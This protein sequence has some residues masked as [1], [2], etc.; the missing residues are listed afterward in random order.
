MIASIIIASII[1]ASIIA[2][3]AVAWRRFL[4]AENRR[5]FTAR[6]R[7]ALLIKPPRCPE[8]PPRRDRRRGNA[9]DARGANARRSPT[10]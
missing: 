6:D 2:V 10:D 5:N 8:G 7:I 9:S 3:A 1:I 4:L